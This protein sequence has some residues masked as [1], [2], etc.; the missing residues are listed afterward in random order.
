[1][2]IKSHTFTLTAYFYFIHIDKEY[3]NCLYNITNSETID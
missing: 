3:K 1:L 2:I